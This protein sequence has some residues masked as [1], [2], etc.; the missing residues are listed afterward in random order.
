MVA[1]VQGVPLTTTGAAGGWGTVGALIITNAIFG[2]PY[3]NYGIMYTNPLLVIGTQKVLKQ[4]P[5]G[6]D[7]P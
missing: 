3:Y 1:W 2:L 5:E 4:K 6:W 7:I